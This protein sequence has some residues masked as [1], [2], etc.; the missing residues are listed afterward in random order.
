M[1]TEP[2]VLS[3]GCSISPWGRSRARSC[4]LWPWG[5]AEGEKEAREL[6]SPAPGPGGLQAPPSSLWPAEARRGDSEPQAAG[7]GGRWGRESAA[8]SACP[9]AAVAAR[10]AP[11]D[12]RL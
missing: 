3:P 5:Q 2:W 8:P 1:S 12:V 4:L 6:Q 9:A 7:P 11:P 10:Q